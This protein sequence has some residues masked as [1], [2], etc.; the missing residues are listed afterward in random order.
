MRAG[1]NGRR[2]RTAAAALALG[3]LA[4]G[5]GGGSGGDGTVTLRYSWWGDASRAKL[6]NKTVALFEKKHPGITVKTDFLEYEDFWKKFATQSAG[7]GAPDVFQNSAAFLRE[8]GAKN[9]LLDLTPQVKAGHLGT[10]G[11]R[12]GL[13]KAGEVDGK[14]LAVPVG[15]NTFAL[16]Y[17]VAEFEKAGVSPEKGWTWD[18]YHA[19]VEKISKAGGIKGAAANAGVMYL[20]DLVLRQQDK[21][22]YT[23]DGELGFTKDDLRTWWSDNYAEVEDGTLVPQK[24]ADQVAP[25]SVLA[26]GLAAS[27]FSWDNFIV[28]WSAETD[29]E[30]ALAPLPTTDG[31]RT[32]QYISSLMLSG[33]ARTRHPEEVA[34]FIDFMV[35]DPEVGKIMGYNRGVL[36]TERQAAAY[37]PEGPDR[38]VA[39]YEQQIADLVEPMT[40]QPAGTS[41]T[42]AA[43][44]RIWGDVAHGTTSVAEGVDQFFSEAEQALRS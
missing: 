39:E 30:L 32:A 40:P 15:G 10:D 11:F 17:N 7:G 6:I 24:K 41:V 34:R 44:L 21:A 8:Y 36:A 43:F 2:L 35:H 19:A 42:E 26:A 18:Q 25:K 22:F 9:V 3:L 33:Y 37:E 13:E 16:I 29:A 1:R 14:L 5:C 12:A 23:A 31:E 4:A 27:E 28:R 38:L 20:Y